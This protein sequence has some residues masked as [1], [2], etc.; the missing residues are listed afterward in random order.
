MDIVSVVGVGMISACIALLLRQYRP[1]YAMFVSIGAG[2]LILTLALGSLLPVV[3]EIEYMMDAADMPGEYAG[4]LFKALGVC[5]ITQIACDTC[6]DA[7]ENAIASKVEMAGK[8]AVLVISLPL[9][10]QILS[11]ASTLIN[12]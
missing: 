12:N 5:L 1:E 7:G 6:K 10:R 8:L 4:V 9:F 11:I 3:D 2:L